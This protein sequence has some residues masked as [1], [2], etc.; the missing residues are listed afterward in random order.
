MG[1]G[2]EW[3]AG[4]FACRG[5]D[6]WLGTDMYTH[7]PESQNQKDREDKRQSELP[8]NLEFRQLGSG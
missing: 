3:Q 1:P 7:G 8:V 5:Q 2:R 6:D 4:R